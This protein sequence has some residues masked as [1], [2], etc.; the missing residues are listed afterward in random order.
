MFI[1]A[2]SLHRTT[3]Q[4]YIKLRCQVNKIMKEQKVNLPG[5]EGVDAIWLASILDGIHDIAQELAYMNACNLSKLDK[6]DRNHV[7]HAFAFAQDRAKQDLFE[8][9]LQIRKARTPIEPEKQENYRR[10]VCK[11]CNT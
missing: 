7:R 9:M 2:M 8:I 4:G 1:F 6:P 3:L 10:F 5:Y 11:Y